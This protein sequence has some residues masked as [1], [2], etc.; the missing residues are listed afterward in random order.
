MKQIKTVKLIEKIFPSVKDDLKK[1]SKFAKDAPHCNY[2]HFTPEYAHG[3]PDPKN[4]SEFKSMIESLISR[5]G[6][7]V[8]KN[9]V[10]TLHNDLFHFDPHTVPLS[11]SRGP[12]YIHI[13]LSSADEGEYCFSYSGYVWHGIGLIGRIL[14]SG[15]MKPGR[16][17]YGGHFMFDE[18]IKRIKIER[19]LEKTKKESEKLN[20]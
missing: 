4:L 5:I 16:I 17:S 7:R 1:I 9:Y 11:L 8:S 15:K 18:T 20:K 2:S 3:D 13:E 6:R 14:K 19:E 10:I 12:G